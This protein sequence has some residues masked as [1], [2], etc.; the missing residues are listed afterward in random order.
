M[1]NLD[2]ART[3]IKTHADMVIDAM[4]IYLGIGLVWKGLYFM[5]HRDELANVMDQLGNS[6]FIPLALAHYVVPM[7][8][9]GGTALALGLLTRVA[10]LTQ[11]PILLGAALVN[12]PRAMYFGPR[13][14]LEFAVLVLFLLCLVFAYGAGRLSMDYA[15]TKKTIEPHPVPST[16]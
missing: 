9:I 6:W 3:W 1:N 15:L 2:H 10:A 12:L 14:N 4:R 11:I 8:I 7:H 5:L 16:I 13:Q